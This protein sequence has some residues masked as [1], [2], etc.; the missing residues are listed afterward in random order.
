MIQWT[1]FLIPYIRFIKEAANLD[2]FIF[3]S[4][5][6]AFNQLLQV[7]FLFLG[8]VSTQHYCQFSSNAIVTL[9]GME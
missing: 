3:M 1:A 4:P 9:D 6:P 8:H 7:N 2:F 5:F